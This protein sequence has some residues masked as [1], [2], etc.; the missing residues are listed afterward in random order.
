MIVEVDR[1]DPQLYSKFNSLL[2]NGNVIVLYYAEWCGHCQSMKP[3]WDQFKERCRSDPKYS[4]LQ[5]AE[6]ESEHIG[7]TKAAEE[8]QGFPTIK[9]YKKNTSAN[10]IPDDSIYY[11]DERVADKFMDFATANSL[12]EHVEQELEGNN[13]NNM[14]ENNMDENNM[15]IKGKKPKGTM[16]S[17]SKKASLKGKKGKAP[18]KASF[19]SKA[20]KKDTAKLR[21]LVFGKEETKNKTKKATTASKKK[22]AAKKA[23]AE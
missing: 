5:V 6:V 22:S 23:K 1:A 15:E 18:A 3:E 14:N 11:Q 9:F 8:A 16:K 2:K 17:K 20:D 13:E 7:N 4:H 12:K 19:K 10:D 21:N